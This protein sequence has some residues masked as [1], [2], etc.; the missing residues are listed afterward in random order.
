MA[1]IV[2]VDG[3]ASSCR[4]AAFSDSG[5]PLAKVSLDRHA[6]LTMGVSDAWQ[7]IEQ[8]LEAVREQLRAGE[9]WQPAKLVMGLAGSLR[10][11]RREQFL[12]LLPKQVE[13]LLVTDGFAQLVGASNGK[14]GIC[15]AVGTGSVMHWLDEQGQSGMAGGWGFPVGDEGSG[16]WLGVRALQQ[17]LASIDGVPATSRLIDELRLLIGSDVSA[18]Q[19]WTTQTRASELAGLA[20]LVFN[21]AAAQDALALQ[22]IDEAVEKIL[23][24]VKRAPLHLPVYI[25]GGIGQKLHPMLSKKLKNRLCTAHHDALRGLWLLSAQAK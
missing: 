24:L 15:V 1:E 12:N 3:G 22:L 25:V 7:H 19:A 4:L 16:A 6:S 10:Q 14:P 21:A 8:G 11:E 2:V 18:I 17:Y 20:P 23:E 9:S 13:Q 5:Q